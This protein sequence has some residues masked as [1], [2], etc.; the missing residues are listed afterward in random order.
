MLGAHLAS[1]TVLPFVLLFVKKTRGNDLDRRRYAPLD[2]AV[3]SYAPYEDLSI[4]VC[5]KRTRIGTM[6]GL[7]LVMFE[8]EKLLTC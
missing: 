4:S 2:V 3:V 6:F 7:V 8:G 5:K 1:G